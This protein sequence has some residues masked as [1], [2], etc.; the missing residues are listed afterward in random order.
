VTIQEY[1]LERLRESG[2]EIEMR[3]RHLAYF[4]ELAKQAR[5]HLQSAD[6]LE[7][8][9]RLDAEYDNIR[10]ALN[11]AQTS[12]AI[13]EGLRLITALEWFWA[14]RV[15]LQE[16]ILALE[17]LLAGPLP[18][19]Q[20]LVLTGAHRVAGHLQSIAGNKI[21]ADAHFKER[22]RL[23]L[24]LGPEGKV[25]KARLLNF[26]LHESLS[27]EPNQIHRNFD[28]VLKLLQETGDQWEMALLLRGVGLELARG[29]DSIGARQALEQSRILFRECG[30]SIGAYSSDGALMLFALEEGKYA[31]ARAQLEEILHFYRQARLDYFIDAPLWMLGV[32]AVREKDYARAK[33]RYT[34]CLLFDQQIGLTKQLA[35]CLIGFAGIASAESRF[36]RAAQLLVVGEAEVE[37]RGTGALENI[38]RI[39]VHRLTALLRQELGDARFEALASQGRLMTREQAI[40]YALEDQERK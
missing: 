16:P 34:E 1:S 18:A 7:W 40:A 39:E 38:D 3:N 32:I 36:E 15:H 23:C 10:V 12:S 17:N 25:E 35:E 29:G 11:W 14:W 22:E 6:Q 31:E 13:A 24:L 28:E 19:D 27:K 4:S 30:D 20:N 2:K 5:S 37:A 33:E 21:S 9:H 8:L 26:I